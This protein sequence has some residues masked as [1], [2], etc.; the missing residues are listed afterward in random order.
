M[1]HREDMYHFRCAFQQGGFN[2]EWIKELR[3]KALKVLTPAVIAK[4]P[5]ALFFITHFL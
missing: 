4:S 3:K 5:A 1:S 2:E